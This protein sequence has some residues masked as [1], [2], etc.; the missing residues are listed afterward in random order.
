MALLPDLET[1][2]LEQLQLLMS[3]YRRSDLTP[4]D[5]MNLA[6]RL[7]GHGYPE[8]AGVIASL[9]QSMKI[10]AAQN[11]LARLARCHQAIQSLP[12]LKPIFADRQLMLQFYATEGHVFRP[13]TTRPDTAVVIFT[14]MYNNFHFSNAVLDAVLTPLGVARLFLKDTTKYQFFRG[15]KDLAGDLRDM[16]SAILRLLR[17]KG[18]TRYLFTGFSSGGYPS[19]YAAL[20]TEPIGYLGYSIY[21]DLSEEATVEH[22]PLFK[23]IRQELPAEVCLNLPRLRKEQSNAFP[24]CIHYGER[25][26]LDTSHAELLR[27]QPGVQV[28]SIPDNHHTVPSQMLA[29]GTFTRGFTAL[30]GA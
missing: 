22:P 14:T 26:A 13:G 3:V 23:S 17:S 12:A 20:Q 8:A 10:S 18:I 19:L 1:H 24:L 5:A 7:V 29:D 30:L 27:G 2:D 15:V 28:V 25:S 21:T 6:T 16:P 4:R 11:Y 9:R